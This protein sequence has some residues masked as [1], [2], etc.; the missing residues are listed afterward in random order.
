MWTMLKEVIDGE[1]IF[2]DEDDH[3]NLKQLNL[4]AE[5]ERRRIWTPG[6]TYAPVTQSSEWLKLQ[7]TQDVARAVR[8]WAAGRTL[9]R[10]S[11]FPSRR[12]SQACWGPG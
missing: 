4:K 1:M 2:E 10:R 5:L 6:R 12:R 7:A 9:I 3:R 11:P 8:L